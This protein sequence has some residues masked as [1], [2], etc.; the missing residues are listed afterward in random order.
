MAAAKPLPLLNETKVGSH[1]ELGSELGSG[2]YSVVVEGVHKETGEK[3]AI[4]IVDKNSTEASEMHGELNVMSKL[5]HPNIVNFKEVFDHEDG[6]YVVLEL[7]SGGELFDR[8][9]ELRRFTEVDAAHTM[10]EAFNA[11]KHVHDNG[12]VHRDIKPENLL[13]ASK[14]SD[15]AVKLADFGFATKCSS[16]VGCVDLLGTPEYMAP[17]LIE[18]RDVAGGYGKPVDVWALGVVL[19]IL[20]SGI[21]PF[22]QEDEE[23]MLDAIQDCKWKWLGRNWSNV[24]AEGKD[25]IKKMLTKNPNNRPTVDECLAHPWLN[26]K[27]DAAL[28]TSDL[29][30][31]Q[32]RKKMKAAVNTILAG[33]KM[34]GLLGKIKNLKIGD[35]TTASTPASAEGTKE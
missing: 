21:H 33:N 20:L 30:K 23:A 27:K 7:I 35:A 19:Y 4:K 12:Y 9:I 25:M 2:A 8:V 3:Y 32:A 34:I 10:T 14:S 26:N 17:E 1:Y 29:A 5:V 18:L 13:L 28:D 15:A 31:F 11:V 24:S 22:Q 6:F 16:P